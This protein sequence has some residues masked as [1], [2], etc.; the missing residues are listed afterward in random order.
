M[1]EPSHRSL[2]AALPHS[3]AP[4]RI[5]TEIWNANHQ[6]AARLQQTMGFDQRVPG[7]FELLETIPNKQ[8]I[9]AAAAE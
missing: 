1:S 6:Q 4:V 5:E 8:R 3:P 2:R 9:R 7:C